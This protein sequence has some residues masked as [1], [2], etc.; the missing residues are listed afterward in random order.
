MTQ[1]I[2]NNFGLFEDTSFIVIVLNR[3]FNIRAARRIIP[4][5]QD[6]RNWTK[7]LRKEIY[8]A[9]EVRRKAKTIWGKKQIQL[10]WYCRD[11]R[12]SVP[13]YKFTLRIVPMKRSQESSSLNSLSRWEQAHVVSSRDTAYLRDKILQV[14]L[15]IPGSTRYSQVWTREERSTNSECGSAQRTSRIESYVWFRR[16]WRSI[17]QR[18]MPRETEKYEWKIFH[19]EQCWLQMQRRQWKRNER[20]SYWRHTQNKR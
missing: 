15:K 7:L 13:Y 17:S 6:S 8:D 5:F 3:E 18:R 4:Y 1:K 11:G 10:Y 14:T 9:G 20:R 19:P 12:N 2:G 16:L